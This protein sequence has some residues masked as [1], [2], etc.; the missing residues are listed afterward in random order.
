MAVDTDRSLHLNMRLFLFLALA[1]CLNAC[2]STSG[3]DIA[4]IALLA[5]FEGQYREIGYNALYALRMAY[6]D[7]ASTSLQLLTVDDGGTATSAIDRVRALN[8]DPAVIVIIALGPAATHA[9]VQRATDRPMV[10]IGNW[11][12]DR[13]S[14]HS[15]Y[16]ANKQLA[17]S[18]GA[19][20]LLML[21]QARNLRADLDAIEFV[22]S[23][24]IA[25]ADFKVRYRNSAEYAPEPNILAMLSY[26]IMR[27]IMSAAMAGADIADATYDG[28]S[29]TIQFQDGY[30]LNA[31]RNRFIYEEGQLVQLTN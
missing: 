19:G 8:L 27:A 17:V 7:V 20:D 15:V 1:L 21:E 5:P 31:P 11:G 10:L 26:D 22:S 28:L 4:K 6:D 2:R 30:W 29:G 25:S 16:A 24:S 3:E 18:Q 12:H 13:A 14:P 23:G 9:D